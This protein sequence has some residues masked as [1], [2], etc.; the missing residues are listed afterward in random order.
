MAFEFGG[1][2]GGG[3]RAREEILE[4]GEFAGFGGGGGVRVGFEVAGGA[5]EAVGGGE[6][7]GLLLLSGV[8]WEGGYDERDCCKNG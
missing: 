5:R 8:C 3:F 7:D 1:R 6:I 4:G 2:E